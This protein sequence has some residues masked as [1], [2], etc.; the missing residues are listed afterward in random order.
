MDIPSNF[1]RS[2]NL[3]LLYAWPSFFGKKYISEKLCFWVNVRCSLFNKGQNF[4]I[5]LPFE[6]H[7]NTEIYLR[8]N[9]KLFKAIITSFQYISNWYKLCKISSYLFYDL[10]YDQNN[11]IW[12]QQLHL[13]RCEYSWTAHIFTKIAGGPVRI[14]S[15]FSCLDIQCIH[16]Y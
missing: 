4:N 8:S 6:F 13:P 15:V 9:I 2:L 11:E 3:Y 14:V 10:L 7:I 1:V 16:R 12:T 5:C